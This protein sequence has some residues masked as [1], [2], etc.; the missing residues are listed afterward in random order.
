MRDILYSVAS[1]HDRYTLQ[2]Y[3]YKYTV[4]GDNYNETSACIGLQTLLT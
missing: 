3:N 1:K 2:K 4:L